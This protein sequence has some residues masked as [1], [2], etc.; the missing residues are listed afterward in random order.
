MTYFGIAGITAD[1][2][3]S[4]IESM[5]LKSLNKVCPSD[6]AGMLDKGKEG[7]AR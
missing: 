6:Y 5:T 4:V 2:P 1:D 7:E 3:Q